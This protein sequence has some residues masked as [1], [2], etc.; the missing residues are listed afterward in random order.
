MM[1][2]PVP[3]AVVAPHFVTVPG[4]APVGSCVVGVVAHR[5]RVRG[6]VRGHSRLLGLVAELGT[7]VEEQDLDRDD[8][9]RLARSRRAGSRRC[10]SRRP[11]RRRSRRSRS[12]R[13]LTSWRATPPIAET[14]RAVHRAGRLAEASG[15]L[16]RSRVDR[17]R[18]LRTRRAGHGHDHQARGR[19]HRAHDRMSRHDNSL[20]PLFSSARY[21]A[22]PL[23]IPTPDR[24]AKRT[25]REAMCA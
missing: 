11:R 15:R 19:K 23:R 17:D 24:R 1:K 7:V 20:H 2:Q 16:E 22:R 12:H 25:T 9:A 14:L 18:I 3:L 10:R 8:G 21:P 4:T 13:C 5:Q 6:A